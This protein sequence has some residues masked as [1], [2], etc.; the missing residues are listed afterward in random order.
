MSTADGGEH[1]IVEDL[2]RHPPDNVVIISRSL[3]EY[4]ITRY[5]AEPDEGK[6]ILDWI[7]RNYEVEAAQGGNPLDCDQRGVV[8]LTRK[9][10]FP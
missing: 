6:E 9:A 10:D 1:S 8:V 4:G 2:K 5:G 7:T 3:L